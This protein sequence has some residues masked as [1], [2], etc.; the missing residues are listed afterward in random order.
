M[1]VRAIMD[2]IVLCLLAPLVLIPVVMLWGY[3]GCGSFDADTSVPEQPFTAQVEAAGDGAVKITAVNV[4]L[5][6]AKLVFRRRNEG[7]ED[8]VV[9][10]QTSPFTPVTD[11]NLSEATKFFYYIKAYDQG[12]T[13]LKDSVTGEI[14]TLPLAP[15]NL[16]VATAERDSITLTWDKISASATHFVVNANLPGASPLEEEQDASAPASRKIQALQPNTEY[17]FQI[18]SRW[19]GA[20]E[21][22]T[23][24]FIPTPALKGRT[25]PAVPPTPTPL[26][27][28]TGMTPATVDTFPNVEGG[29]AIVRIPATSLSLS[30]TAGKTIITLRGA[31]KGPVT[32]GKVTISQPATTGNLYDSG[33]DLKVVAD[34]VNLAANETKSLTVDYALDEGK[35]LLVAFDLRPVAGSGNLS[36]GPKSGNTLYFG[37]NRQEAGNP[38]R[39]ATGYAVSADRI[40]FIEKIEVL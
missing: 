2:W 32:L 38:V 20:G 29:C 16:R 1:Q 5:N 8:I 10:E 25:T 34:A 28:Y 12:N 27:T 18:A 6:A 9:V 24:A 7:G 22:V 35:D 26:L 17:E 30:S 21:V 3:A 23:S 15:A 31:P 33:P 37:L 39:T 19:K 40:A 13:F 11:R 4:P 14:R 36:F